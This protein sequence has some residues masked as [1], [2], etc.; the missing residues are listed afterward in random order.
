M[1]SLFRARR[2]R[3]VAIRPIAV[4]VL[5]ASLAP[6]ACG[7]DSSG[8]TS[9][10]NA[11][12]SCRAYATASRAVQTGELG[13]E[14]VDLWQMTSTCQW[15]GNRLTCTQKYS[16]FRGDC[17][18]A[19]GDATWTATYGSA[20]DFV[21]EVAALPPISKATSVAVTSAAGRC[22]SPF[23]VRQQYDTT[24]R[25]LRVTSTSASNFAANSVKT[26]TAWDARGRPTE[27]LFDNFRVTGPVAI[28]YDDAARTTTD[29]ATYDNGNWIVTT[30]TT[31]DAGGN[32]VREVLSDA[33]PGEAR[34]AYTTTTTVLATDRVCK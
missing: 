31:H 1:H 6:A 24:G 9:P 33:I 16:Q 15:T 26:F 12:Q 19:G 28:R 22:P 27:G 4:V 30:T 17:E 23:E 21:D 32:V 11:S 5:V 7:G 29:V 10:S 14:R 25:L 13:A 18:G 20:A 8:P 3:R 2:A 34:P